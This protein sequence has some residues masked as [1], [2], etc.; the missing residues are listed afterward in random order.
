M[1]LNSEENKEKGLLGVLRLQSGLVDQFAE[2]LV[3]AQIFL[4]A[5]QNVLQRD[6]LADTQIQEKDPNSV[7]DPRDIS[8]CMWFRTVTQAVLVHL[9]SSPC[10]RSSSACAYRRRVAAAC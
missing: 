7:S 1:S 4:V 2:L 5:H 3:A 6:S 9:A 10:R 8:A